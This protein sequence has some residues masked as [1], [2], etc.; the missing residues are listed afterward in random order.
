MHERERRNLFFRAET[1]HTQTLND[2]ALNHYNGVSAFTSSANVKT[3]LFMQALG[4]GAK[5]TYN[6]YAFEE[7]SP[8]ANLFLS[9]KYMIDR[10]DKDKT[11]TFFA[12]RNHFGKTTL[13]ENQAYLPLGFLAEPELAQLSF[14]TSGNAFTFQNKLFAAATGLEADVWHRIP[15]EN[16]AITSEDVTVTEQ[17][18]T[19]YCKY[20]DTKKNGNVTYSFTADRDG[21]VC[22]HLNLPKRND[23]YVSINDVELYKE[24]I[25][26]PQMIAVDDVSAG[27]EIRVRVVCK[28]DENSTMT[29]GAAI[30]DHEVFWQGYEILKASTLELTTFES[31]YVKG[32]INCDRDGLLYVSIP[33][34]GNREVKVDGKPAQIQLVGDCMLG[35]PLTEGQHLIEYTYHNGAFALGWKVSLLCAAVFGFLLY[36]TCPITPGKKRGKYER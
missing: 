16:L 32:M 9:L 35:V 8:V 30:L 27:D 18:G 4:Y 11:S 29:V 13:L 25:S 22:I 15:G 26:L 7:S 10:D 36:R 2:G 6:R 24:T 34:N 21:F 12:E 5:N 28:A 3:T 19:G 23:Y 20:Q 1:T 31:S 33:Q 17:D 14:D